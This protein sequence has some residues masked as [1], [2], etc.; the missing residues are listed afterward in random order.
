MDPITAAT[1]IITAACAVAGAIKTAQQI[2]IG[3][4][5]K[6]AGRLGDADLVGPESSTPVSAFEFSQRINNLVAKFGRR[7]GHKLD[8]QVKRQV[9]RL[10][11]QLKALISEL[12]TLKRDSVSGQ[13]AVDFE[14][15][16]AALLG[17]ANQLKE[18]IE[19]A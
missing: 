15:R 16:R 9:F 6:K 2:Y 12:D 1:A 13:S 17:Q 11:P 8:E 5:Q 4:K 10:Q 18:E 14:K 7:F 19:R 3:H